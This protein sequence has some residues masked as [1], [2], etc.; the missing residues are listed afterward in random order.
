VTREAECRETSAEKE[1]FDSVDHELSVE[2][3]FVIGTEISGEQGFVRG[4]WIE[5][6]NLSKSSDGAER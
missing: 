2:R 5:G 1:F 6:E 4:F 3:E